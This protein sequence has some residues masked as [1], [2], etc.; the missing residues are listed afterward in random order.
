MIYPTVDKM[1]RY[2]GSKYQ[3]VHYAA[4]RARQMDETCH[5]QMQEYDSKSNIGK[6]LEELAEGL[7]VIK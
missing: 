5:Y 2:I 7:I 6:A 4:K 3:L 1:K